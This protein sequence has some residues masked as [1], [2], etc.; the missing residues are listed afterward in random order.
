[1]ALIA[2]TLGGTAALRAGSSTWIAPGSGNYWTTTN[3]QANT[4]PNAETDTATFGNAGG[5]TVSIDGGAT[6]KDLIFDGTASAYTIAS[7]NG[8]HLELSSGGGSISATGTGANAQLVTTDV[9]RR[10]NSSFTNDYASPDH[11]LTL[12]GSLKIWTNQN[13]TLTLGGTNTGANT[14]SGVI[15][16]DGNPGKTTLNKTGA[17]VWILSGQNNY[18]GP[19]N[20]QGGTLL[21]T[22]THASSAAY[23]ID[24]G[25][26]G[27]AGGKISAAG[28]TLTG[29]AGSALDISGAGLGTI[30]SQAALTAPG[31]LEFD[32]GSTSLD[33]SQAGAGALRFVLATPGSSDFAWLSSG[34]LEIGDGVLSLEN[35]R[36]DLSNLTPEDT[37]TYILFYTSSE[38]G[39]I[40]SLADHDLSLLSGGYQLTLSLGSDADQFD[41]LELHVTAAVP[42]PSVWSAIL[43]G[44]ALLI[45]FRRWRGCTTPPA[46]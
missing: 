44:S 21:V 8:H 31:M 27:G 13:V 22:G 42:E 30:G 1:M 5:G 29:S 7:S 23:T 6:V 16:D 20:I 35:F 43:L 19:T 45:G 12:G 33:I 15:T 10:G 24:G 3:W 39:I 41:T 36:F 37:G 17:G 18:T 9:Y 40:G 2:A 4:V 11:T 32:L 28:V 14:V 25:A 38:D 34:T 46:P 26:L